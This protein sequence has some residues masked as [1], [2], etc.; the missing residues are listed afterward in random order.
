ML[1][2][3]AND[4][5][6]LYGKHQ[7]TMNLHLLRHLADTVRNSGPLWAQSIFAFEQSNGDLVRSVTSKSHVLNEIT[8][9]YILRNSLV[10][11]TKDFRH[12]LDLCQKYKSF[13][14]SS[15]E[16]ELFKQ[17]DIIIDLST[18]WKSIKVNGESYTSKAYKATIKSIDYCVQFDDNQIGNIMYYVCF[19][20]VVY[21]LA[22]MLDVI[23]KKH[24]FQLLKSTNL[25]LVRGVLNIREK[26]I[27]MK[28]GDQ[29]IA[30]RFPNNYEKT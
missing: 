2:Q 15:K 7:V 13:S 17:H 1:F 6:Y 22:N 14:P 30:C 20:G 10:M 24:Q 25:L 8:D 27:F 28:L 5:E 21:A 11:K 4:F 19:N 3:F 29:Q 12:K 16:I 9:H 23:E 18:L 26:L